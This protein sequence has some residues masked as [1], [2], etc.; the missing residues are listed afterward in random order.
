MPFD[1]ISSSNADSQIDF[2]YPLKNGRDQNSQSEYFTNVDQVDF[3]M[4]GRLRQ[5]F[6]SAH[7]SGKN[8]IQIRLQTTPVNSQIVSL[9]CF[10]LL[11]RKILQ[12]EPNFKDRYFEFLSSVSHSPLDGFPIFQKI[13]E[14]YMFKNDGKISS[15]VVCQVMVLCD[16]I[17]WVKDIES[18][19]T[20]QGFEDGAVRKVWHLVRMEM[21]VE[22]RQAK[23]F[24]PISLSQGNWQITDIDDM[25][26]GNLIL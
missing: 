16:E 5:L 8:Q 26:D 10:P 3:M 2:A 7:M 11:C 18:G 19:A 12:D 9:F 21:I 24:F 23:G 6:Q 25:L 13:L 22:A 15:T 4:E 20:I 14:D 17:F 1:P